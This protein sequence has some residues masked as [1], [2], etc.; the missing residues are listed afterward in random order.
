ME[1]AKSLAR[2]H[3]RTFRANLLAIKNSKAFSV[4][5]NTIKDIEH[6]YL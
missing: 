1:M 5:R 3:T 2:V 4:F 6:S